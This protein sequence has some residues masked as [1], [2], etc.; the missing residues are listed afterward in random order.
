ME[1][2]KETFIVRYEFKILERANLFAENDT[3]PT[4]TTCALTA[5]INY[6]VSVKKK[7]LKKEI[8]LY[9]L[10]FL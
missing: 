7:I 8:H 9:R 5:E 6:Q 10:I 1:L 3:T 4:S 2:D